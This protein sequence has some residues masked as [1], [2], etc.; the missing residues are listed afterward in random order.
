MKIAV[1]AIAKNEAKFAERWYANMSEA[2]EICVLD[3]GSVDGTPD[4]FRRLGAKV[5]S[6]TLS[7]FD[8]GAARNASMAMVSPDADI[9]VCTD[10]DELFSKGWANKVRRAFEEHREATCAACKFITRFNEDGTP[11]DTMHYW[12][13]HRPCAGAVWNAR[14]HEYLTYQ[15]HV[16]VFIPDM[17]LE[18]H[19]DGEKSR[20]QY[21]DLLRIEADG[22][23]DP[24][25]VHYYGRELMYR[26]Y[27]HEAIKQLRKYLAM[28]DAVWKEER[29][30]SMRFIARCYG[31]LKEYEQSVCWFLRSICECDDMREPC[32]DLADLAMTYQDWNMCRWAAETALSRKVRNAHYFTEDACWTFQPYDVLSVALYHLGK[33]K[34]AAANASVALSYKPDDERISNNL[35]SMT[36]E[37]EAQDGRKDKAPQKVAGENPEEQEH[38]LEIKPL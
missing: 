35:K 28:P 21:L 26:G 23:G 37:M 25:S 9:L 31:W 20:D 6:V 10:I 19:P 36:K 7:P 2:D 14:V 8:F 11:R 30:F 29:A 4:I 16:E 1:Y 32:C 22:K 3:T 18:H 12:K 38:G 15:N 5:K 33:F 24:R 13:I 34:E 17:V 27:Y